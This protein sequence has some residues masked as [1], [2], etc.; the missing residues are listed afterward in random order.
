MVT[1]RGKR[2]DTGMPWR[3]PSSREDALSGPGLTLVRWPWGDRVR[4]APCE[5]DDDDDEPGDQDGEE[6]LGLVPVA[7]RK[8]DDADGGRG[9]RPG[10]GVAIPTLALLTGLV[11]FGGAGQ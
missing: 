3:H 4:K 10:R 1:D 11:R 2:L 6:V 7:A 8:V 5:V 9:D